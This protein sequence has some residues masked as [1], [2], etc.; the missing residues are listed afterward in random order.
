MGAKVNMLRQAAGQLRRI[1]EEIVPEYLFKD[2]VARY[3]E[4]LMLTKV[5]Q[6]SWDNAVA[7]K[8]DALFEELSRHVE[9]H[10]HSESYSGGMPDAAQLTKLAGRVD[11]VIAG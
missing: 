4:N 9:G 2:V 3:R 5:K 11:E 8:I 7:D 1:L 10:S 6:I